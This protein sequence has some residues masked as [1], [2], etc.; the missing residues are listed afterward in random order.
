MSELN[1]NDGMLGM[2]RRSQAAKKDDLKDDVFDD[3]KA[4][5]EDGV[6][7]V[8][9]AFPG[10]YGP[11]KEEAYEHYRGWS[12]K[13]SRKGRDGVKEPGAWMVCNCHNGKRNVPCVPCHDDKDTYQTTGKRSF[14]PLPFYA[15]NIIRYGKYHVTPTQNG[16]GTYLR[17][18]TG[19]PDCPGCLKQQEIVHWKHE[20]LDLDEGGWAAY[21]SW[22]ISIMRKCATCGKGEILPVRAVCPSC[23][24]EIK[25][26][27]DKL[28]PLEMNEGTCPHCGFQGF[29]SLSHDCCYRDYKTSETL[30]GCGDP[31]YYS[32]YDCDIKIVQ[33][34]RTK[35]KGKD[36][37]LVDYYPSDVDDKN[38]QEA[39][40]DPFEFKSYDHMPTENQANRLGIT[41][42]FKAR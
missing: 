21:N 40:K 5:L 33:K 10:N 3:P 17:R 41:N 11:G 32:I 8:I 15:I 2:F 37:F 18:C 12:M 19:K 29:I 27:P 16:K 24:K 9:R 42:P 1:V 34:P 13:L 20:H 25:L 6:E 7:E 4:Y 38:I 23:K 35:G 22:K 14:R 26:P 39:M 31:A 28:T 36:L 30:P